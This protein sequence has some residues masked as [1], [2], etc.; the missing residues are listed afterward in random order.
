MKKLVLGGLI[1]VVVLAIAGAEM[2]L[3]AY[4]FRGSVIDPPAPATDFSLKDQNG[5]AFQLSDQRGKIVLMFFG[6]TNCP[7]VC[8]VTLAQFK[9]ARAQLSQQADRV[10]FVFITV[11]PERDTAE[12]MKTYLGAI[13]PTIIGLG[14]SQGELEQV[15]RAYGVYR[16]KQPGQSQDEY[17]DL[18]EHSSRVYLVDTQGNLRVTFPFGLVPDDVEQDVRYLLRKG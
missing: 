5:Q 8:P 11:D 13:D 16:Q 4:K 6:Y 7:D 17:A 1:A 3:Q 10:R 9:Q 14:G 15:W 12:K 2:F 18:L